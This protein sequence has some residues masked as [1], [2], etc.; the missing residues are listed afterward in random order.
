MKKGEIRKQEILKV[1]EELFCKNGYEKTSIQNILD[2]LHSSK[3]S[4]YHHYESKESLLEAM[5]IQ[6][7][8]QIAQKAAEESEKLTDPVKKLNCLMTGIFPLSEERLSFLLMLLPVFSTQEGKSVR[9]C[10][11]DAL[12]SAFRV[13]IAYQLEKCSEA[14]L[15]NY[16][17]AT[18]TASLSILIINNL[19]CSICD[20]LI[21][22][23]SDDEDLPDMSSTINQVRIAVERIISAPY[24]SLE[25]IRLHD[26]TSLAGK[27]RSHWK[28]V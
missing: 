28:T 7:A 19:W 17:D 8:G 5:C 1:A 27:I 24:G 6:R 4:F 11:C 25:L 2:V 10:Y 18:V 9:N 15:T 23:S 21:G 26:V 16:R 12:A 14:G 22:L 13:L 3:G 20:S